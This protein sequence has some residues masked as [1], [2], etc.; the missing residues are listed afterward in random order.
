[1]TESENSVVNEKEV[2]VEQAESAKTYT[3]EE[4]LQLIQRETD[5]RVTQA[6]KTQELYNNVI[7]CYSKI[8]EKNFFTI[9]NKDEIY[10]ESLF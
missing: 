2:N 4:V 10:L 6:L 7:V 5:K 8:V 1:M 9:Y 3:Q